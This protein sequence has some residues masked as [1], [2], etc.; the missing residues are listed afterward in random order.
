MPVTHNVLTADSSTS[1]ATSYATAS[2]TPGANRLVLLAVLSTVGS[3]TPE[4]PTVTGCN[5]T[6]VQISTSIL[7]TSDGRL[8]LFRALGTP[9]TEA[10]TIEF[11]VGNTQLSCGWS[12]IE[13]IN[14]IQTGTHGS[15]AIIQ[16]VTQNNDES[17]GANITIPLAAFGSAARG[18]VIF[19]PPDSSL[20][21]VTA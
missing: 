1:D 16:A 8:T 17:G 10:L 2:I 14:V 21:W 6:W 7:G 12:V 5:L 20:F 9:S 13:F 15:G 3:G 4:T 11:G 19:A 18:I